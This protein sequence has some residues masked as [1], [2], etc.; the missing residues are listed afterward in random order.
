M[1][2]RNSL[3]S[4]FPLFFPSKYFL[5]NFFLFKPLVRLRPE[6]LRLADY[7]PIRGCW[8]PASGNGWN[9]KGGF[10][11]FVVVFLR[12]RK[13]NVK[14]F[15]E[16]FLS[17]QHQSETDLFGPANHI[18]DLLKS[19]NRPIKLISGVYF[20]IQCPT[21]LICGWCSSKSES[22]LISPVRLLCGY[23]LS[24][25]F[26]TGMFFFT[27]QF[28]KIQTRDERSPRAGREKEE[29]MEWSLSKKKKEKEKGR[30]TTPK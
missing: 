12:N 23:C 2:D 10:E 20:P 9:P 18:M 16:A 6:R 29:W 26:S 4:C 21:K 3:P 24:L 28:S 19:R 17:R 25:P 27:F 30:E 13:N 11:T 14:S 8:Q 5:H 7:R 22:A 15:R 1:R